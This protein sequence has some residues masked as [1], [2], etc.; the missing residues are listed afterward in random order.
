MKMDDNTMMG[1]VGWQDQISRPATLHDN[2][3]RSQANDIDEA[4]DNPIMCM[5][6]PQQVW[7]R[8]WPG[9]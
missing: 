8:V 2:H 9:L 4:P 6:T 1:M 7:P 3:R 5:P